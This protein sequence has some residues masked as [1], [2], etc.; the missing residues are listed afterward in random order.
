MTK[1]LEYKKEAKIENPLLHELMYMATYSIVE[2][3]IASA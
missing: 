1:D 3:H 2:I